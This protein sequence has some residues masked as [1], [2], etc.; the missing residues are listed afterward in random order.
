[1]RVLFAAV[2][3]LLLFWGCEKKF[4][5]VSVDANASITRS[6]EALADRY[7]EYW[8]AISGT[9][10][11]EGFKYELPYLNFIRDKAWYLN[12]HAADRKHYKVKLLYIKYSE[13]DPEIADV[14]TNID[15]GHTDY[16]FNDRW[17]RINGTWYHFY[18]Q[19]ILPPMITEP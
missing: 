12:F 10:Y 5:Y 2:L 18:H 1:M 16:D 8:E 14:R 19:T 4:T 3:T 7:K 13:D 9:R 17:Y 11:E 6:D 15:L